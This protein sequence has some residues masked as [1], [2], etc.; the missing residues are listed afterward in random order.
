[1]RFGTALRSPLTTSRA[2][3]RETEGLLVGHSSRR[4]A[5]GRAASGRDRPRGRG[6]HRVPRLRRPL[7]FDRPLRTQVKIRRPAFE[8]IQAHGSEGYPMR[9]AASC[10][11]TIMSSRMFGVPATSSSSGRATATRSI[12]FDQIRIQ[13]EADTAGLDVIGYYPQP[14][15]PPGPKR[16][17]STPNGRGRVTSTS[18]FSIEKGKPVDAK[19]RSSPIRMAGLFTP[20]P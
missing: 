12:R 3:S 10:S 19:T 11:A 17:G 6:R 15:R 1:M 8:A 5:L 9:S 7:P 4:G 2:R 18:S 16:L 13:R 20:S 14:P